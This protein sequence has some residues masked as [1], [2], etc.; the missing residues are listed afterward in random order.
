MWELL[1]EE[2]PESALGTIGRGGARALA[3]SAETILGLPG[4]IANTALGLTNFGIEKATGKPS[5]LPAKVPIIQGSEDIKENVTEPLAKE[6][7]P[8]DYIQPQGEGEKFFD[9]I[10]SDAAALFFPAKG[11][12]PFK[13]I[14]GR[15]LKSIGKSALANTAKWGAEALTDSPLVGSAVKLGTLL[16][17]DLFGSRKELGSIK[18][19]FYKESKAKIPTAAKINVKP[20]KL[21]IEKIITELDRGDLPDKKFLLDRAK[22]FEDIVSKNIPSRK[23][24]SSIINEAGKPYTKVIPGKR[25]GEA[26]VNQIIKIKQDWN[27][28]LLDPNLGSKSKDVI[29]R[30]VGT[31]N[32]AIQRYG[33]TNPEFYEPWKAAEEL[34]GALNTK[35]LIQNILSKNPLLENSIKNPLVKYLLAPGIVKGG[36]TGITKIG[37]PK[38][39][40]IA[41]GAKGA[42]DAS[43]AIQLMASSPLARKY[44]KD[45]AQ[46]ALKNDSKAM[47]R[48]I[49]KLN[50]EAD[51]L[52]S[53]EEGW[54]L[55]A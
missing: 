53:S 55:I 24:A 34:H 1:K 16:Y 9:E 22:S 43:R 28:H 15:A 48:D 32:S 4:D 40:G 51:K 10:A 7:L 19:N 23:E 12:I 33:T 6:F 18:D 30:L 17:T 29:K 47:L 52:T 20:E 42:Y 3:R 36:I 49:R 35:G 37:L 25:G 54:E 44:Y 2:Q 50:H 8:K 21:G 45:F 27:Q 38:S 14:A 26:L 46:S 13:G 39:L 31:A 11:S 41:A 5:P